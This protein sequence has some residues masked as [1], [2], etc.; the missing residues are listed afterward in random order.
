[1]R[2]MSKTAVAL[3]TG[4]ILALGGIAVAAPVLAGGPGP[5]PGD[6]PATQSRTFAPGGPQAGYGMGYGMGRMG[7]QMRGR[8]PGDGTCPFW[9]LPAASGSVT[10]AQKATLADMAEE[11]KLAHDLYAAF[12]ARFDAR[13]FDHIAAAETRHL[14]TVRALLDRYDVSD[15]TAGKAAGQFASAEVKA[16]YDRL[17]AQGSGSEQA[18]LKV[19]VTVEK[20][21]VA[22]LRKAVQGLTAA[23]V[24]Q[25]YNRLL[26]TSQRHLEVFQAWA[27]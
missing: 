23:D 25:V 16:T 14:T 12:A 7:D 8:G 26:T 27:K 19:G 18:A 17:L 21:D 6:R 10:A 3:T 11:E 22:A 5:G 9:E 1:M 20:A 4:G 15:P 2:H 13:V 24:K